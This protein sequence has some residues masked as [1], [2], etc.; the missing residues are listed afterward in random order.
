MLT[1]K[2]VHIFWADAPMTGY[3]KIA[4]IDLPFK[5]E[6]CLHFTATVRLFFL[7]LG[8]IKL[9]FCIH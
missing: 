1:V 7:K 8:T 4:N 2:N 3:Q 9:A 5:A 6:G